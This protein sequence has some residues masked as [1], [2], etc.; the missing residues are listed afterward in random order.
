MSNQ[1][2]IHRNFSEF[3]LKNL[4]MLLAL[5]GASGAGK[6]TLL[7]VLA[8]RKNVGKIEGEISPNFLYFF[9]EFSDINQ[10]DILVNGSEPDEFY[11]RLVGYVEQTDCHYPF[12]TVEEAVDFSARCRLDRGEEFSPNSLKNCTKNRRDQ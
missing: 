10:G 1:V 8:Q 7:D 2:K 12:T 4:G 5:M 11:H 3:S 9:H 6:S